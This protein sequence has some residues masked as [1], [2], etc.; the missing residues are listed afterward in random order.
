MTKP[1]LLVSACLLGQPVRYDG[2]S[3]PLSSP[4]WTTLRQRFD[5]I[6]VCPECLGGLPTP[7]PAAEIVGGNG[8]DALAGVARIQSA[9]GDDVSAAFIAGA[10]RTLNAALQHGCAQALLKAN[11]PSCGNRRIY[12][13]SFSATL[14][15]GQGVAAS[16]LERNG[17]AVWNETEIDS[18]LDP[19]PPQAV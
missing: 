6:P 10:E 3:K 16:L 1:T 5:L 17:I 9:D 11:S 2:Q 7:R 18:L 14:R 13:G 8:G 12:D 15:D 4:R 19:E